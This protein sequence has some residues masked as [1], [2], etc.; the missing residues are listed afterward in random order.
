LS[1]ATRS[2]RKAIEGFEWIDNFRSSSDINYSAKRDR[3]VR[4]FN[5]PLSQMKDEES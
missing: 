1:A 2:M 4:L 3:C 5:P